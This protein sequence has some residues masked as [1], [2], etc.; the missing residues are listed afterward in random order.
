MVRTLMARAA[1]GGVLL[2]A[3]C[4]T[5]TAA[6]DRGRTYAQ[7]AARHGH[8]A[9]HRG[10]G[11]GQE[12]W[13][14]VCDNTPALPPTTAEPCRLETAVRQSGPAPAAATISSAD[15]GRTWTVAAM[16][17]PGAVRLKVGTRTPVDADCG[18]P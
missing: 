7:R 17:S 5:H 2:L 14:V 15:G 9:V 3:G 18:H 13:T 4:A 10:E 1:A 8:H 6:T 11:A 16:P 12:D